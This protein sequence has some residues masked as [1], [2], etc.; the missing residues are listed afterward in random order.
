[1]DY[2]QWTLDNLSHIRPEDCWINE[3]ACLNEF[4]IKNAFL[5]DVKPTFISIKPINNK[6][7]YI[8]IHDEL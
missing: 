4:H 3:N 8:L 6:Y 2:I 7:I 5:L 1:M